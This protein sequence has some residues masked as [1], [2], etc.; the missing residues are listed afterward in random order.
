MLKKKFEYDID[1]I[2]KEIYKDKNYTEELV[3]EWLNK[4]KENKEIKKYM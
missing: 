3:S 4:F 1:Q 2:E